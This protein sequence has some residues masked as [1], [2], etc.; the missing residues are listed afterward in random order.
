MGVPVITLV[1]ERHSNRVGFTILKNL[2]LDKLITFTEDEYVNCAVDFSKKINDLKEFKK[3]LRLN[4]I[5]SDLC[6]KDL[7]ARNMEKCFKDIISS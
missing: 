1:G 7:H 4:L 6:D 5:K 2:N 3:S